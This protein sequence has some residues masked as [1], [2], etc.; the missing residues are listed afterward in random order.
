MKGILDS[1]EEPT[2]VDRTDEEKA[3]IIGDAMEDWISQMVGHY[4][5]DVKAWDVVN[6]PMHDDGRLRDGNVT[7]QNSDHF[8]WVKYLGRDYAVTAFK[9]A[10][11]YGNATDILFI[12]DYNLE[13]SLDKCDSLIEYA[14]YIESQGAVVDGIG[15]QMHLTLNSDSAKIA[16]MFQKLAASGKLIKISELDVRLGTNSPTAEQLE[17][18]SDMYQYAIEMYMEHIPEVQRY[19]ITIWG[20]SDNEQEHEYWLPDESP[21]LWDA[22][23]ER[24]HAYIGVA[25]GLAGRDVSKDFSGELEY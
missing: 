1:E 20:I 9:L 21:N 6:E 25:N 4:K 24:K 10:R 15:T 5:N 13:Y 14:K 23:Y 8:Y 11:Q 19:G 12:N 18:Q 16:Q 2:T 7:E 22:D 3:E 17:A